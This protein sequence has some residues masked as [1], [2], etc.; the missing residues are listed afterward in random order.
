M[1][2]ALLGF[3]FYLVVILVV[4][5]ITYNINKSHKDF[6]IAGRKL[7]PWVVAFSERASGES[8]W[9]LLGLPGAAY[10]SGLMEF[11]TALGCVSG[12]IFYWFFI[13]KA[14]RIETERLEAFT[15]PTFLAARFQKG[16]SAIRVLATFII[17]FFFI[18]YLAAQF[19]G[20][21][22]ILN[23]T[24]GLNQKT[25]MIIGAAVIIFYTMM[26]GF[27][28]VAWTD[29][30]QGIIMI[31]TLV[32]LPLVGLAEL[33]EIHNGTVVLSDLV[34]NEGHPMMSFTGGKTG[35][36]AAALIT[37]GLSWALGYMGQ[38]HL[39]TRFMAIKSADQIKISRRIAIAWVIPAFSGAVIIGII[40]AG[41]YGQGMFDDIEKVMPHLANE[42]LPAWLA[43]IFVSGA[44]AAMMS[45]ADSQLLVISS[46]IIED[47][48]HR[49]LGWDVGDKML[50]KGS[51]IITIV[52]GLIGFAI[53]LTSDKL[54]FSMVS[55]AWAGLGSSFGPVILLL[56]TWK[57][58]THQGVIAGLLTGF[59][60]TVVWSELSALDAV[61]S[62]RFVSWVM[63]FLAVWLVSRF[64]RI[65]S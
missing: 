8:A 54:I 50:L 59:V 27:F 64:T 46:S 25:G 11:W 53:A 47:F 22:K 65:Q 18:F 49:T 13:A 60:T 3:I 2:F 55:Y 51:R 40:G 1:N 33:K 52:V 61:I 14:L 38:P 26:G 16:Q 20:A 62:V 10:A 36:A 24:F 39:L 35:W 48:F 45:T 23:V 58:V 6:F 37:S 34:A 21:G 12:I 31:G 56:L 15:L 32:V 42:L 29:M 9:L 5:F 19:N 63:A 17:I 44:I 30:V 57:K 28:A 4:G 43:G 41:L 7:N